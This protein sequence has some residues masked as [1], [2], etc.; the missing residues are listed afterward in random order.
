MKGVE[1]MK[2]FKKVLSVIFALV[3]IVCS[4]CP[5]AFAK[6]K[7]ELKF[8]EDGKFRIMH[9]TDTHFTDFPFEE[10]AEKPGFSVCPSK[11]SV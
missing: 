11:R 5:A 6:N 2:N 7:T 3:L 10:S 9:I 1:T 4:V 8:G